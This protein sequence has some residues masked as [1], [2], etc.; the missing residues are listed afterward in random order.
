MSVS[1]V[2]GLRVDREI[3]E[4]IATEFQ[5]KHK[6]DPRKNEKSWVKLLHK[7]SDTKEVL[8]ANKDAAVYIEGFIDGIDLHT[9]VKRETL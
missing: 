9:H 6:I 8:S 2:G 5:A 4:Y 7:C 1:D 3:A